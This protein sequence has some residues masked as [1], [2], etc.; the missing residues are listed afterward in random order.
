MR[1]VR[2]ILDELREREVRED[3]LPL[4]TRFPLYSRGEPGLKDVAA[5]SEKSGGG[6]VGE[7]CTGVD[8][9][10]RIVGE[11]EDT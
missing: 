2:S 6:N 10:E 11:G 1:V 8:C 3:R 5:P 9:P 4:A 7:R